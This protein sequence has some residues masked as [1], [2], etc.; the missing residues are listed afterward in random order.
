M[1]VKIHDRNHDLSPA[2]GDLAVKRLE[3]LASRFSFVH[4]AEIEFAIDLKKR[5]HPVHVA[6]LTLHL[7]GHRL[8]DLRAHATSSEPREAFDLALGKLDTELLKLKEQV[9]AH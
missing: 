6:K 1:E 9:E 8:Q 5:P 4:S 7:I 2:L 3:S